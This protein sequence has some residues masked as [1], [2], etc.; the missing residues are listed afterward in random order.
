MLATA[1]RREGYTAVNLTILASYALPEFSTS[2]AYGG[3][4]LPV[5]D[6]GAQAGGPLAVEFL[7]FAFDTYTLLAFPP[8]GRGHG[9]RG[10][11]GQ[12]AEPD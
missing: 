11:P 5:T 1:R 12:R 8:T 2:N 7:N 9:R 3:D 10:S 4:A 6:A